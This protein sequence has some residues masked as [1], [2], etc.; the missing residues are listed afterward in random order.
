MSEMGLV[1]RVLGARVGYVG[2][3]V[4]RH[5]R[6]FLKLR[7]ALLV[8]AVLSPLWVMPLSA[9]VVSDVVVVMHHDSAVSTA[10]RTI[11]A[12]DSHM[13][14]VEYG[15]LKY[16]L[17]IHRTVGR[18]VWVSHGTDAGILA[19]THIISW[20]AFRHRTEMT[21]G[22]D[23]VLAC[24]SAKI[25][26]YSSSKGTV[27][28]VASIL[29]PVVDSF[30]GAVIASVLLYIES[31]DYSSARSTFN[32]NKEKIFSRFE[33][34]DIEPLGSK[35]YYMWDSVPYIKGTDAP[36]P[37]ANAE[38]RG[39][40]LTQYFYGTIFDHLYFRPD[41]WALTSAFIGM[42][43]ALI[44]TKNA[45]AAAV[46]AFIGVIILDY[47]LADENGGGHIVFERNSHWELLG[48]YFYSRMYLGKLGLIRIMWWPNGQT[49][50][51][52]EW[53]LSGP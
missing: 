13:Q 20:N 21:P 18:V 47:L 28:S 38:V 23:I 7:T 35:I 36:F 33:S 3:S 12:N 9:P 14:V 48:L 42:I 43:I 1:D 8:I 30:V 29:G 46:G 41:D 27:I 39:I 44:T 45:V 26:S 2:R 49:L 6:D 37:H 16:A 34:G 31:G 19:S 15:S 25:E 5:R 51:L 32:C 24:N 17:T 50:W 4:G 22:E 11:V 53:Q 40:Y 52:P 10:V